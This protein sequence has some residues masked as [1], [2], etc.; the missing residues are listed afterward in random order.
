MKMYYRLALLA[1]TFTLMTSCSLFT[2][3]DEADVVILYTTDV[4]GA[5]LPFD[6]T[7]NREART[8]LA[9][10]STYL[11]QEREKS[12]NLL[13]FDTGDYLQ[14]QP[15][16]Y[17]FNYIDTARA[18]IFTRIA[19][20][21]DYDAI[22]LGNHDIEAGPALYKSRLQRELRMPVLCA[23]ALDTATRRPA[24]KPYAVWEW[25]NVRVAVLGMITPNI[26]AWLPRS[27]WPGLEFQ[28]MVECAQQWVPFIQQNE[29]PD[30]LIGLFHAGSDPT[31]GGNTMDTYLNE[32]GSVPAAV[33]V[34]GFDLILTGHDHAP[35]KFEVVNV[36]GDTVPVLNAGT[37][38]Y[39][40]GRADIHLK[41]NPETKRY[42]KT[43]R[44]ELVPM[45]DIAADSVYAS[46]YTADIEAVN[47]YLDAPIG[48]LTESLSSAD[49]PF[50]PSAFIDLLQD[51]QLW[52]SNA[53]ISFASV[54]SS[55]ARLNAGTITM[56]DLFTLY[57]YENRLFT[58]RLTGEEIRKYLE[59]GYAQQFNQ[60]KSASDELLAYQHDSSGAILKNQ[61]G[62]MM[63]WPTFNYT[64]AAGINYT[65]DVSKPAGQR[66]TVKS[67][68]SGEPFDMKRE[69]NVA[70]N[71][72]QA[73]G[74]GDY[75]PKGLG[76]DR[77]TIESRTVKTSDIDVRQNIADY[78]RE[79]K[80]IT[81]SA[82]NNFRVIPA[83]WWEKA[84]EREMQSYKD[85]H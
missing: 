67:L 69:Y 29:H 31:Y 59:F 76:W 32:N 3:P 74:G 35:T 38:S 7:A 14:G 30:I 66:V 8:S 17:Y 36:A 13:F 81:P 47:N 28:D 9:N 53:D 26:P 5:M 70:I 18:H 23:N 27:M 62:S 75:F 37:R 79:H 72:Y 20:E 49:S 55:S 1:L 15:S 63:M 12:P 2:R 25:H 60:M 83:D 44:T 82:H 40:V 45:A 21:L 56:R 78:I 57:K 19:N 10:V 68:T 48:T 43:V 73:C 65:I 39:Y 52:A 64:Y 84:R 58:V 11:K 71:S 33:K 42:A 24:F 6:F 51:V 85:S 54:L 4:H 34:P 22:G 16:L 80:T 46:H 77:A 61:Y 41:L 50:G